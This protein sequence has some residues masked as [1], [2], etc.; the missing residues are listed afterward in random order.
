MPK[1]MTPNV[2]E[3][4]QPVVEKKKYQTIEELEK[5][6]WE[7]LPKTCQVTNV[8][9]E[10]PEIIL[11]TKNPKAFFAGTDNYVAKIAF[12]LKKKI[13]VRADKSLLQDPSTAKK[14]I[15]GLIPVE[16]GVKNITFVEP[17]CQVVIEADKPGL[18][19][20]KGGE[21]SKA[22]IVQTG[23]T[24]KIV[25]APSSD[26]EFLQGIRYHL[27]KHAA[28]RKKLLQET[29]KKIYRAASSKHDW[30]RLTGLG[31]FR[32]I[33]RSCM[34]VDTPLSKV[35]M[36]CGINPANKEDPYPYLDAL[37]FPLSEL[38]ALVI[39][40]A[41]MDHQGFAPYLYR[42][43]YTGPLYCTEPTRDIMALLQFDYV[44]VALKQ[45][46]EPP[47]TEKDVKELLKH[48]IVRDYRETTDITPDMRITFHNASHILGSA[49]VHMNLG[50]GAHN[51]VYSGD[52]KYGYTRLFDTMDLNYP[53]VE[54]LIMESTYGGE[55]DIQPAR[56]HEDRKLLQII[57]D[58]LEKKG[59]VLIPVFAVGR[60][61]EV[62]L[63]IE[64]F[65]RQ[66]L[67]PS[68]KV[69]VDG[70]TKE[71]SAIHTAYPE[72]LRQNIQRR[73]LSNDSPFT[74]PLFNNVT[75]QD[76]DQILKDGNAIILASSGMLNGGASLAYFY[77]MADDPKN[78]L[79]FTGYQGDGSLGRKL[80]GGI[81]NIPIAD[82]KGRTKELNVQMRV[83]SLEGYS[84]HSDRL[85]LE[86]YI[87]N[88]NPKPKR[89]VVDHGNRIKTVAFAKF[90]T[91]K[92]GISSMAIRNLDTLR[93]R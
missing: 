39:S 67:L 12:E 79:V 64:D 50:D 59:N 13:S 85:Q 69:Y 19:I 4:G 42:M 90:I 43:G 80:Q 38:D 5:K 86:N 35:M 24:P 7:S 55:K 30:V 71:A 53:R 74:S 8:D 72:Y 48:V 40:H 44:D 66:G 70:L 25:R 23:W 92:Y 84:G 27:N 11:Y 20:G 93:L 32:E 1:K 87:R 16:A 10:G 46:V 2:D 3:N 77:K 34:L 22:I 63:V 81:R 18:V 61:Q 14:Q 88:I 47:Y 75:A 89:I 28:E 83:E 73:I 52:M 37:N 60:G 17:F 41:H 26:S 6:V 91:Q 62:T 45:G 82:E 21:T 31:A 76:R 58:T 36:D 56:E 49:S 65:Y 29:A 54:T 15:E 9:F 33:G 51:L 78:A 57:L 68:A